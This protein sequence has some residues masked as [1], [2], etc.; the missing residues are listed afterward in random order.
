MKHLRTQKVKVNMCISFLVVLVQRRTKAVAGTRHLPEAKLDRAL[1]PNWVL[2]HY[3]TKRQ[4]GT[5]SK[6]METICN[7]IKV[8]GHPVSFFFKKRTHVNANLPATDILKS[9]QKT[10]HWCVAYTPYAI[11]EVFNRG[12][13]NEVR[14]PFDA[15]KLWPTFSKQ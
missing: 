13:S 5:L 9:P 12:I 4:S 8:N 6:T 7:L 14:K 15:A 3:A 1:H 10:V 2:C 11:A